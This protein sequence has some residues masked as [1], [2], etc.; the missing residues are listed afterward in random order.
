MKLLITIFTLI[1]SIS[2]YAQCNEPIHS[3]NATDNWES[4][5]MQENPN[6]VRGNSHWIQYDLG[7]IYPITSSY[8]W[9]YNVSGQTSKGFKDVVV[10]YSIDGVTWTQLGYYIFD[11]ASGSNV[12]T[13]FVGPDFG[14]VNT[15]F[16][17]ITAIN[18]YGNSCYGLAECKFDVGDDVQIGIQEIKDDNK[19]SVS[20]NPT[21]NI[22][23]IETDNLNVTELIIRNS[24]GFEIQ[25]YNDNIPSAIDVSYL[26]SGIY[27]LIANTE[28][29]KFVVRKFV[30]VNK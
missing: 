27:F 24:T 18:N 12:Y 6:S 9:N 2:I 11:E 30:K 4:C 7:Y 1:I 19:L 13:G 20:P 15:R 23:K 16:I 8:V 25:R 28:D 29:N 22:L 21:R 10:D 17:L 14:D 26:P 3:N 5:A